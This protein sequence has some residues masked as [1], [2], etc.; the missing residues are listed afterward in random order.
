MASVLMFSA[1]LDSF[2]LKSTWG[3]DDKD[4]LFVDMGTRENARELEIVRRNFPGVRT[5]KVSLAQFELPNK[6]IPWRNCILAIVG[7]QFAKDI[8][9]AFTLGDTT[10]DK[11]WVFKAQMEAVLNYFAL[12]ERKVRVPGPFGIHMPFKNYTKTELVKMYL[13]RGHDPD[14]LL[15][16]SASCYRGREKQC[17]RCRSCLRKFV[18]LINNGIV[19]PESVFE[20]WPGNFLEEHLKECEKKNRKGETEEVRQCL[21]RLQQS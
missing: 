18:A 8:F 3:F 15:F 17:G 11:D 9:F 20:S 5:T 7:A 12:D 4:C 14:E 13:A 2:I 21:N 19:P 6:I 10:K 1:G 16:R